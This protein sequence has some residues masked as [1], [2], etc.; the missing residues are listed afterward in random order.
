MLI[1]HILGELG[2]QIF[3]RAALRG[4]PVFSTPRFSINYAGI[5]FARICEMGNAFERINKSAINL[6]SPRAANC[7]TAWRRGDRRLLPR[8]GIREKDPRFSAQ[9]TLPPFY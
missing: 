2:K 7:G 5:G 3:L 1:F 6:T 9:L 8:A 4:P